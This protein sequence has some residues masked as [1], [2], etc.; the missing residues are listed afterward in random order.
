MATRPHPTEDHLPLPPQA[1]NVLLALGDG[2]LHGYGII[3]AFEALTE[4]SETLLPGSLYGTLG[5]MVA[6]SLLEE[7]GSPA[8]ESSSGPP[9]RYYQAT[10]LGKSVARAEVERMERVLALARAR[11]LAPEGGKP[12]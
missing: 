7:V 2:C 10:N 11:R 6:A 8:G 9:R 4:G 12:A 3:Q 5:R 1:F